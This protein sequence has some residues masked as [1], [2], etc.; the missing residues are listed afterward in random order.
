MKSVAP[1]LAAEVPD[2]RELATLGRPDDANFVVRFHACFH[3][4]RDP[5][6]GMPDATPVDPSRAARMIRMAGGDL[7][8][9][10]VHAP[11]ER[12]QPSQHPDDEMDRLEWFD[13]LEAQPFSQL[14]RLLRVD[15]EASDDDALTIFGALVRC[16]PQATSRSA[17]LLA[18]TAFARPSWGVSAVREHPRF[19][20][21]LSV[22][23][24]REN[25]LHVLAKRDH[26]ADRG[27]DDP[28]G[29]GVLE[30]LRALEAAGISI[31]VNERHPPHLPSP[32][33][34]ACTGAGRGMARAFVEHFGRAALDSDRDCQGN[35]ALHAVAQGDPQGHRVRHLLELGAQ[36]GLLNNAGATPLEMAALGNG[37][38]AVK[39]LLAARPSPLEA[40][41]PEQLDRAAA[42]TTDPEIE[43]MLKAYRA[44][45]EVHRA[46]RSSSAI[47]PL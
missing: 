43:A 5:L 42:G 15:C 1:H 8:A 10:D 30:L 26:Y 23:H 2:D 9:L 29:R 36:A 19:F 22:N 11:D 16:R 31:G 46:S 7:A 33:S 17:W 34:R 35:T 39:A 37:R 47:H 18:S 45:V 25:A 6:S 44:R 41:L 3:R 28:R 13:H 24:G 20:R 32:F 21:D 40:Y 12:R 14:R 4:P 38:Q 27:E